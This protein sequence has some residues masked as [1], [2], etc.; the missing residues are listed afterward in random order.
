MN[1][2]YMGL[3]KEPFE[4]IVNGSKL[5]EFRLNDKKRQQIKVGDKITFN[6]LD[7]RDEIVSVLVLRIIKSNTFYTLFKDLV[8]TIY[9]P[10]ETELDD[11]TEW[12]RKVYSLEKELK[13]GVVGIE[14]KRIV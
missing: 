9:G 3:F 6:N 2:H 4:N 14:I 13:F 12:M 5:M 10:K 11:W 8:G 7:N 1:T